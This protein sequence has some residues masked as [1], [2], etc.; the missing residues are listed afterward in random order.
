VA[1][2]TVAQDLPILKERKLEFI[3]LSHYIESDYVSLV[4]RKNSGIAPCKSAF[5]GN[6]TGRSSTA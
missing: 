6:D 3:S 2:A 4:I 1:F 5:V